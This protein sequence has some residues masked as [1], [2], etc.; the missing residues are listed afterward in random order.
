[1][2]PNFGRGQTS[3]NMTFEYVDKENHFLCITDTEIKEVFIDGKIE[4]CKIENTE[5]E[6]CIKKCLISSD[7][8]SFS[9]LWLTSEEFVCGDSSETTRKK[10][11]YIEVRYY[12]NSR[13][14]VK[15]A[16]EKLWWQATNILNLQ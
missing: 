16:N 14:Y 4:W 8:S 3:N 9:E 5:N 10:C 2:I 6:K 15:K 13:L 7:H 1:M 11:V 12:D